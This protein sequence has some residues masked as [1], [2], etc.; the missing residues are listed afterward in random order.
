MHIYLGASLIK[1]TEPYFWVEMHRMK[2]LT[3]VTIHVLLSAWLHPCMMKLI[4]HFHV[5][6]C[7]DKLTHMEKLE[8]GISK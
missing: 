8:D 6:S 1:F 3:L 4:Y 5:V 7:F 2:F